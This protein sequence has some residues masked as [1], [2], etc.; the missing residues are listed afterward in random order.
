[1]KIA[2]DPWMSILPLHSLKWNPIPSCLFMMNYHGFCHLTSDEKHH[3][4]FLLIQ[5]TR[6]T[7]GNAS[8]F[9]VKEKLYSKTV[10]N[11]LSYYLTLTVIANIWLFPLQTY[12]QRKILEYTCHTAFF[13][14]IVIVQWAD[15]IICKTRRN[16]LFTQGMKYVPTTYYCVNLPSTKT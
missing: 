10:G 4:A 7:L 13:V 14:S 16:S 11:I 3:A 2:V 6:F 15:I 12:D 9:T 5:Q 8:L 1:M